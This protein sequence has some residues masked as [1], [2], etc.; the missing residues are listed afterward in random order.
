MLV[1]G[2]VQTVVTG[3]QFTLNGNLSTEPVVGSTYAPSM[4]QGA[5]VGTGQLSMQMVDNTF[6]TNFSADT[7][8]EIMLYMG[9]S[10]ATNAEFMVFH[11]PQCLLASNDVDD[12]PR[13]LKQALNF[14]FFKKPTTT[15]YDSTTMSLHDSLFA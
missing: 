13:I 9:D 10:G 2:S 15:G 11:L 4:G 1:G 8:F 3:L 12:G 6:L 7:P 5:L 14:G